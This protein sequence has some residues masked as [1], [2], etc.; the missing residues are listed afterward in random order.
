[1]AELPPLLSR[2][3]LSGP[4]TTI[5]RVVGHAQP[6]SSSTNT[7]GSDD[8]LPPRA[9]VFPQDNQALSW[10]VPLVKAERVVGKIASPRLSG[11]GLRV[12]D[13][14]K[15][16]SAALGSATAHKSFIDSLVAC[17]WV[18]GVGDDA[19]NSEGVGAIMGWFKPGIVPIAGRKILAR[20]LLQQRRRQGRGIEIVDLPQLHFHAEGDEIAITD[21][22]GLPIGGPIHKDIDRVHHVLKGGLRP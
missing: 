19:Y 17:L 16:R 6:G 20:P 21:A 2:V 11:E 7:R 3:R 12:F 8:P 22:N 15:A 4:I 10:D 13:T 14:V 9:A 5:L 18:A 1:M